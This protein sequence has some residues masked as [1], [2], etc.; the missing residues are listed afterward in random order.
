MNGGP[1]HGPYHYLFT[2]VGGRLVKRYVRPGDLPAV[3][4]QCVAARQAQRNRAIARLS[5]RALLAQ[6]RAAEGNL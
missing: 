4:A 2:R 5:W 6:I 3:Q 1:A